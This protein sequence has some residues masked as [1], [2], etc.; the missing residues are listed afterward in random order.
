MKP[1]SP[2][3]EGNMLDIIKYLQSMEKR[4][5]ASNEVNYK[6]LNESL[7]EKIVELSQIIKP[8]SGRITFLEQYKSFKNQQANSIAHTPKSWQRSGFD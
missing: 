1:G 6:K 4:L 2:G 5:T 8:L 7:L 3:A